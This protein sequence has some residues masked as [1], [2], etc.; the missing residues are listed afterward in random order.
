M[1]MTATIDYTRRLILSTVRESLT[2]S[3]LH[4]YITDLWQDVSVATFDEI[5][6]IEPGTQLLVTSGGF[7]AAVAVLHQPNPERLPYR[8][9]IVAPADVSYG[10]ARMYEAY[11]EPTAGELRVFR[12]LDDALAWLRPTD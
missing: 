10:L 2:D 9:A 4:T 7:Q 6:V 5:V 3:D 11:Q 1:G 8:T 12:S